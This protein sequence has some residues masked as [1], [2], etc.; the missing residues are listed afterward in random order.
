MLLLERGDRTSFLRSH[1]RAASIIQSP[2][3]PR[4]NP[5][6]TAWK[7]RNQLSLRP[8]GRG[9]LP[10]LDSCNGVP[11]VPPRAICAGFIL[12]ATPTGP[13]GQCSC[14]R[15]SPLATSHLSPYNRN[16]MTSEASYDS[17]IQTLGQQ[18]P[19]P[20]YLCPLTPLSRHAGP[21]LL[22]WSQALGLYAAESVGSLLAV[23]KL[24]NIKQAA[25]TG[26]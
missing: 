10:Y 24:C 5:L 25:R 6:Q 20:L 2:P 13:S 7:G 9:A 19:A 18:A 12:K 23:L 1:Q 22:S 21:G 8:R 17:K 11:A 16:L 15:A 14:L 3:P 4:Q 26:P